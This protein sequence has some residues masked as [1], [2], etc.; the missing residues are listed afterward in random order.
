MILAI[1]PPRAHTQHQIP[2]S[3]QIRSD[4]SPDE[5]VFFVFLRLFLCPIKL[6]L[7]SLVRRKE[8]IFTENKT[9]FIFLFHK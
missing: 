4:K 6:L 9:Q 2:Q 7:G 1:L 5:H 8:S 3:P